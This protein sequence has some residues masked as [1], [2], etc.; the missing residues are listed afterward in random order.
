MS[1][2]V[3]SFHYSE[4]CIS[5]TK[6]TLVIQQICEYKKGE[7][8]SMRLE[9]SVLYYEFCWMQNETVCGYSQPLTNRKLVNDFETNWFDH[10]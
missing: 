9:S 4:E 1:V 2:K 3:D 6:H 7:W 8:A 10:N 5:M